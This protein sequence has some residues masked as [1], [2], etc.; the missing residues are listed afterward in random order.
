MRPSII[1][2]QAWPVALQGRDLI[3]IAQT[4]SGKT[5]AFLLPG[6]VHVMAQTT[7]KANTILFRW[8]VKYQRLV[9]FL[10][11]LVLLSFYK[12]RHKTKTQQMINVFINF[13][14]LH[15]LFFIFVP[16]FILFFIIERRWTHYSCDGTN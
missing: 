4:G 10:K 12:L 5:L 2:S 13:T 3:G 9:S 8:V 15:F 1:Q 7:L 6:I 16:L 14:K 11:V